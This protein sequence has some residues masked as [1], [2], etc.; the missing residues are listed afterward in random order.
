MSKTPHANGK[1]GV[2][3]AS[4]LRIHPRYMRSVHLERDF[5]DPS[6]SLGYVL[7][8]VAS[9]AVHRICTGLCPNSTQ[10]AFRIAGDYGSGKSSFGLALARIASGNSRALPKELHPFSPQIRVKPHLATGDHEPL[11]ITVLRAL[12]T[13][14][15]HGSKPTTDDVLLKVRKS[16]AQARAE[17]YKGI[18]LVV[19]ELGKN[20]E[21]AAQHPESDDIFLLQRLAEEAARSGDQPFVIVVILHQGVAAYAARTGLDYPIRLSHR[22]RCTI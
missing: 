20:L 8:Q 16:I 18:L 21:F 13:K 15:P 7:T 11:G 5:A 1:G 10:R 6:S 19:D 12:G 2:R 3:F 14:L 4:L 17:G 22:P 9:A